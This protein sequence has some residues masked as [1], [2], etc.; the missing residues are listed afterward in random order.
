[1][2]LGHSARP[3]IAQV[4]GICYGYEPRC[5]ELVLDATTI[6]QL[7]QVQLS[8]LRRLMLNTPEAQALNPASETKNVYRRA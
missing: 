3:T 6:G 2:H 4:Y 8:M 1:M 5:I 7:L